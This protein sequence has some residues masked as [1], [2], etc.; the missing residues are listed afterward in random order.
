MVKKHEEVKQAETRPTDTGLSMA[1]Y[2]TIL[3]ADLVPA[4]G[5]TEP[6]AIA[7][8]AAKAGQLLGEPPRELN[9]ALSANVIKNAHSVV[10][11]NSGG[12][13]GI[14][15][16]AALGILAGDAK[17][18]LEV[19]EAVE[20][21]DVARAQTFIEEGRIHLSLK[22]GVSCLYIQ[23]EAKGE[24][25]TATAT[26]AQ[27]HNHFI[28]LA[29][30]ETVLLDQ[31]AGFTPEDEAMQKLQRRLDFAD[32]WQAATQTDLSA[33]PQIIEIL[34]RQ[35][36]CNMAISQKGMTE[37][38]GQSVGRTLLAQEAES[39]VLN[40]AIAYAAAGS[41][42]RMAGCS[43]PVVINSGSGNQ[44]MTL[45]IP[46]I[47]ISRQMDLGEDKLY[48]ALFLANL[49]SLLLKTAIGKLSAYCGAITASAAC[50]AGMAYLLGYDRQVAQDTIINTLSISSGLVCDGATGSCAGKI[51]V[52]LK[53][54]QYALSM[55]EQG[56][57]FPKEGLA[58]EDLRASIA[59]IG[60]LANPG[61]VGTDE[62]LL[63][64]ILEA[65]QT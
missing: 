54:A 35:I 28:Y 56:F 50:G 47:Y 59:N 31:R 45:S 15:F 51:A 58:G 34:D 32:I 36:A 7:L 39:S 38:W 20:A 14:P 2:E 43:L 37:T 44:G 61:M 55:A 42:A 29:Q 48:R 62:E 27:G 19:L 25:H 8:A 5:C 21:A 13:K 17:R 26:I 1:E 9:L 3:R 65:D 57:V 41:D 64:I 16:A 49:T 46:L 18:D 40:Q 22:K 30:D 6:I 11:P 63:N 33:Y 12:H 24:T 23:A 60:R 10:V 53:T 52:G 4:L